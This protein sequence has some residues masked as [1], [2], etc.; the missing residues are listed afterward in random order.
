VYVDGYDLRDAPR[1]HD[2]ARLSEGLAVPAGSHPQQAIALANSEGVVFAM[3]GNS[4]RAKELFDLAISTARTVDAGGANMG[5]LA[6]NA[7]AMLTMIGDYAT[8]RVYLDEALEIS[9]EKLGPRHPMVAHMLANLGALANYEGRYEDAAA[10]FEQA[11][12][13]QE[14]VLG[15]E[16]LD[17]SN[18]YN[19]L[20]GIKRQLGDTPGAIELHRKAL[21]IRERAAGD[22]NLMVAQSLDNLAIALAHADR[23]DEARPLLERSLEIKRAIGGEDSPEIAHTLLSLYEVERAAGRDAEAI[24][25][26][27][28]ALVMREK[29][30]GP[31]HPLLVVALYGRAQMYERTE[32]LDDAIA[33]LERAAGIGARRTV[34]AVLL[35]DV[36]WRLGRLLWSREPTRARELVTQARDVIARVERR[37]GAQAHELD[38]WLASHRAP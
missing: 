23:V 8:A 13:L 3:E 11:R 2:W 12:Q 18:T 32:R 4:R 19:N 20:A 26:I 1:A 35:A 15:T 31:D 10:L 27:G 17:L 6:G 5:V 37:D 28:R 22:R 33:D 29:A 14:E 25:L 16:H 7:G 34:D 36:R 30:L 21:A 24:D 9:R 38:Q